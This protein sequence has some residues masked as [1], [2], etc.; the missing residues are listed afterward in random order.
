LHLSKELFFLNSGTTWASINFSG[1]MELVAEEHPSITIIKENKKEIP[2]LIFHEIENDFVSKQINKA[3]SKKATGRDGISAKL[4]KFAKPF[5]NSLWG[6]QSKA[7]DKSMSMAA[8]NLFSSR[9]FF[10]SSIIFRRAVW[11]P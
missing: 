4:L 3:N 8:T 1:K 2:K 10:Q 5:I 9:A 11:Q 7:F 6:R